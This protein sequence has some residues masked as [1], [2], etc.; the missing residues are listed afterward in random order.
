[1]KDLVL[2]FWC[3]IDFWSIGASQKG[4]LLV[5]PSFGTSFNSRKLMK[6]DDDVADLVD[7]LRQPDNVLQEAVFQR[8]AK[9]REAILGSGLGI[10]K[11]FTMWV[12]IQK[13]IL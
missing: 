12:R 1:M 9:T 2:P 11:L 7:S 5:Y 13:N 6:T 8:H 3:T 4:T 10:T